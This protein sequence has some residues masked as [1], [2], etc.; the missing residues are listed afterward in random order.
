VVLLVAAL[1][2]RSLIAI[3]RLASGM[4]DPWNDTAET[5]CALSFGL[6]CVL[7]FVL[8]LVLHIVTPQAPS[9]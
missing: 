1:L 2:A 5:P 8:R 7:S 9:R 6:R 3:V 4:D